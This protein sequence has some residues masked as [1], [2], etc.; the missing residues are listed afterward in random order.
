MKIR[1]IIILLGIL[2]SITSCKKNDPNKQ[3]DEGRFENN[4]YSSKE[5]G[6]DINI[7]KNWKIITREQN[8][9]Y[10]KLGLDAIEKMVDGEI[11][12]SGLKYLI[13]FKKNI[14]NTFQSTSEPFLV[15]YPGEWEENNVLLKEL[16]YNT[17]ESQ[18]IKIDSSV[19]K[20]IKIDELDFETYEFTIY[21]PKGDA[22][23]NQ[24][25]YSRLINGLTFG[26]NINY[27]NESDK[28]EMLNSWLNSKFK[29]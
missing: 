26:V 23:M 8:E 17:Y 5:I 28:K 12:T 24:L 14:F 3:I 13:G 7:P 21:S 18:G 1:Q 10:E 27:N 29:K 11:N 25:S 19:T 16:I 20:T 6:W 2:T 22:I 4:I 15:E 9:E